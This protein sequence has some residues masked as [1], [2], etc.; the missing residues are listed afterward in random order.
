[1]CLKGRQSSRNQGKMHGGN[2]LNVSARTAVSEW[3]ANSARYRLIDENEARFYGLSRFDQ[4]F[5]KLT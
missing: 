3:G 4:G 5:L 2:C 1:M